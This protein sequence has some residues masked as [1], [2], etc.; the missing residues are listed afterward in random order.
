MTWDVDT[1]APPP[2]PLPMHIDTHTHSLSRTHSHTHPQ[3]LGGTMTIE[4]EASSLKEVE[5]VLAC[6]AE[7][8]APHLVRLM[9]DN[10]TKWVGVL[11]VR[12]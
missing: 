10:M 8:K 2:P 11:C 9:L 5:E 7:G 1:C 3:D 12:M 6:L 4:V